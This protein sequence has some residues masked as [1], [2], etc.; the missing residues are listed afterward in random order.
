MQDVLHLNVFCSLQV[1]A[2]AQGLEQEPDSFDGFLLS[3]LAAHLAI[4]GT[5]VR[6]SGTVRCEVGGCEFGGSMQC[7]LR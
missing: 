4:N 6:F 3:M 1:W 5:L 2:R 7:L